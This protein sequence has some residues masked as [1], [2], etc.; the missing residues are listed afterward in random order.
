MR[1]YLEMNGFVVTW[2]KDGAAG[3][4][5][6]QEDDFSLC[7]LDVMM[8]K[9][10]GFALAQD[11][12]KIQPDQPLLFVTARAM[13][14]DVI[15][16]FKLRADDY[17]IKPFDPE[18]LLYRIRAI[19]NRSAQARPQAVQGKQFELPGFM[20]DYELR[21]LSQGGQT[22]RLSPKEAD[23]LRLFCIHENELI[24]RE[25]VLNLLWGDD[26]YFNGR[27]MDVFVSKL[28]KHF[29][30]EPRIQIENIHGKGFRFLVKE[31]S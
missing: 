26:N 19:L 12:R 8:P 2:A 28:R 15:R 7:I 16:G 4:E 10:D 20:F 29:R 23:L 21:T 25:D 5:K 24:T 14:E 18:E 31:H 17:I 1:D 11:I 13:K 6:Y 27:S 3:L 30:D 22:T 9:K